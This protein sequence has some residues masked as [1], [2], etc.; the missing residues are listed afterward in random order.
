MSVS[1][2]DHT[3]VTRQELAKLGC[4]VVPHVNAYI[5]EDIAPHPLSGQALRTRAFMQACPS[6]SLAE[7]LL[8]AYVF[9]RGIV[10][11]SGGPDK[12]EHLSASGAPEPAHAAPEPAPAALEPAAPGSSGLS[13]L[14][15]FEAELSAL[16]ES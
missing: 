7:A 10:M 15:A 2:R 11:C 6:A 14:T 1:P 9:N 3:C 13:D 8:A 4:S 12:A 5:C 16:S